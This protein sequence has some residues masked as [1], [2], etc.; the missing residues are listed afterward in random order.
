MIRR[1][2]RSTRTDTLFPHTTLFRSSKPRRAFCERWRSVR[3]PTCSE[4]TCDSALFLISPLA[5]RGK[6]VH[7]WDDC[8]CH[9]REDRPAA[10]LFGACSL[11]RGD[12]PPNRRLPLEGNLP[13]L[14]DAGPGRAVA[15]ASRTTCEPTGAGHRRQ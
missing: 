8:V 13:L 14:V 3:M 15:S 10:A 5:V 1:P 7:R 2:P 6:A 4:G 11:L 9:C 12:E